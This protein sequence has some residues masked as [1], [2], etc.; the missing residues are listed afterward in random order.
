MKKDDLDTAQLQDEIVRLL[1]MLVRKG[2]AQST[3][4]QQLGAAGFRTK[5]IAELLGT[6]PNTVNVTL[7]KA[8]KKK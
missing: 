2:E 1:V 6:T 5:R 3:I 4:I 7:Q 8:K